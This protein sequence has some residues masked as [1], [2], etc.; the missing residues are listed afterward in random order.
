MARDWQVLVFPL[1]MLIQYPNGLYIVDIVKVQKWII[2]VELLFE[3]MFK[4][5]VYMFIVTLL[6]LNR[7]E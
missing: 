6:L 3:L 7:I 1:Y 5:Y 2:P 4:I